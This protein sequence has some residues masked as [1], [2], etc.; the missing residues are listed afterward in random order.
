MGVLHLP[1]YFVLEAGLHIL[2]IGFI[3]L[4]LY[5]D[6]RLTHTRNMLPALGTLYRTL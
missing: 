5:I 6:L 4:L 3:K 2:A 1:Q